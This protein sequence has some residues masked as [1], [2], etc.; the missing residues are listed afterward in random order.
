MRALYWLMLATPLAVL[1]GTQTAAA[2]PDCATAD[3]VKALKDRVEKLEQKSG[4]AP[5]RDEK[6]EKA[7]A[8]LL[9]GI[10]TALRVG[11]IATAKEKLAR[12]K[13]S[14]PSTAAYK[15]ARKI[16]T[17]L[18]VVGKDAPTTLGVD[19]W[20]SNRTEI[21]LTSDRPTLIVFW[22]Q[23]CPHSRREVPKLEATY[24]RH[25][26]LQMV[27][28]TKVTRSATEDKVLE[29]VRENSLSFPVATEIMEDGKGTL[30]SY[31]SVGGVPAAAVIKNGKVI[32]RGHPGRLTDS[33]IISWL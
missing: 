7:A 28:V 4:E 9:E 5:V 12:L 10:K 1:S 23:W 6:A 22:E 27:A 24:Q 21:D 19:R 33:L 29:F 32:W 17:E 13:S 20:L 30:S 15:R 2:H 11:D 18:A 3:E 14:Y 8:E 26:G 31:F 16:E 25:R